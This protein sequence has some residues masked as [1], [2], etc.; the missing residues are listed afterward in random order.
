MKLYAD[1]IV[2]VFHKDGDKAK[3]GEKIRRILP[4]R[5]E[6]ELR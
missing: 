1:D 3:A 5:C 4:R 2:A 6:G